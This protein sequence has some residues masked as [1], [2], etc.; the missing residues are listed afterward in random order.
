MIK[1]NYPS[2]ESLFND[3]DHP[4]PNINKQAA[5]QMYRYWPKE[6]KARLIQNLNS[7]NV[8]LRRKSVKALSLFG[9]DITTELINIYFS[10]TNY[11]IRVS[12]LKILVIVASNHN[13]M[14]FREEINKLINSAIKDDSTEITLTII[15]FL[16]QIG[17][18]SL[19]CLK[20]LCRDENVLRAKAAITAII[21]ISD[22]ST[23]EFLKNIS[24]DSSLDSLI[25]DSAAEALKIKV[26]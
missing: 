23:Q 15:S 22:S 7:T 8:D 1:D 17:K 2:L 6:S 26:N 14:D 3:L 25:R 16:R 4:N 11:I 18:D 10:N 20:N 19:P 5:I 21:E 9:K 13:L 12:C 24:I